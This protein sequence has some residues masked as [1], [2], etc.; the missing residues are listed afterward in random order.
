MGSRDNV[1][2]RMSDYSG[3][4]KGW[5]PSEVRTIERIQQILKC[6]GWTSYPRY[7][8]S[9]IGEHMCIF[10]RGDFCADLN[11]SITK[12]PLGYIVM[13]GSGRVRATGTNLS[14]CAGI[15]LFGGTRDPEY[16]FLYCRHTTQAAEDVVF[17]LK[18]Y[19]NGT[20]PS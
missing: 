16:S 12:A 8:E 17:Q 10:D 14:R 1:V 18:D 9:D 7:I 15:W 19:N 20:L 4:P 5:T 13:D 11:N 2:T 3:C 6:R